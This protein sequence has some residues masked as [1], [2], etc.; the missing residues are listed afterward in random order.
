MDN[1]DTI[2]SLLFKKI[3]RFYSEQ[4]ITLKYDDLVKHINITKEE[5]LESHEKP[6]PKPK[7]LFIKPKKPTKKLILKPKVNLDYMTFITICEKNKLQYFQFHDEHNWVGPAIKI[8]SD[9]LSNIS[10][11]F[12]SLKTTKITGTTFYIIRPSSSLKDDNITYPIM[13]DECKLEDNSLIVATSDDD[14]YNGTTD[15][16]EVE[17]E[18]WVH[19]GTNIKYMIDPNT[20]ILYSFQTNEPVGKKIDEF[21]IEFN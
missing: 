10:I 16:D 1:L 19:E 6:K 7:K 5:V 17:L 15:D 8:D 3:E 11:Y 4:G 20:H 9:E 2:K 12:K 18:E 13:N 14:V 21:T